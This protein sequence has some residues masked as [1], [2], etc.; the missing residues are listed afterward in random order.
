MRLGIEGARVDAAAF[1]TSAMVAAAFLASFIA[2]KSGTGNSIFMAVRP[3]ALP[4]LTAAPSCGHRKNGLNRK[5]RFP[6]NAGY[7]SAHLSAT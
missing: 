6:C 4:K 5:G 7:G 2:T 3:H 1:A